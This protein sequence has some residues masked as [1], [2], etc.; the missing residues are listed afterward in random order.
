[1]L[2]ASLNIT[3]TQFPCSLDMDT[4]DYSLGCT[5]FQTHFDGTPKSVA[6]WS[7]ALRDAELSYSASKKERLAIV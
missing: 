4:S 1:M 6:F 3:A 5:L 2:P 7:L